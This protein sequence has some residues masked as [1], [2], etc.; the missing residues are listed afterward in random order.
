MAQ[1][2]LIKV[3]VRKV[4]EASYYIRLNSKFEKNANPSHFWADGPEIG[5][6]MS[7]GALEPRTDSSRTRRIQPSRREGPKQAMSDPNVLFSDRLRTPT[8][9]ENLKK[10]GVKPLQMFPGRSGGE[11]PRKKKHLH[12]QIKSY[13]QGEK[14]VH[15]EGGVLNLRRLQIPG[16]GVPFFHDLYV[17]GKTPNFRF[18]PLLRTLK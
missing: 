10:S 4:P 12:P 3:V 6:Q 18:P 14:Y 16:G 13:H 15:L 5:P 7:Y 11:A 9:V 8:N 2:G 1:N 17:V